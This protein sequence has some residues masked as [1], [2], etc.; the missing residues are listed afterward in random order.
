MFFIFFST[1]LQFFWIGGKKGDGFLKQKLSWGDTFIIDE[2]KSCIMI[3]NIFQIF[4]L[5][6]RVL[7]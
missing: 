5:T 6:T 7:T 3:Y 1:I 4:F 2:D